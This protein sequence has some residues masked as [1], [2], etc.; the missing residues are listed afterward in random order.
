[1][2]HLSA[3][4]RPIP[5]GHWLT[6]ARIRVYSWLL[7][8]IFAAGLAVAIVR[9]L[10]GLVDARG[11]PLGY[12]FMAFWSAARLALGG[13]PEAVFDGA[14]ISAVQHAAVAAAPDIWFPWH[15]PPTTLLAVLPLGLLPYSAAL[16]AFMAASIALWAAF[17][18]RLLPDPRAWIVAAATPA[19]LINLI[20]G[21]NAFLTAA[22]AGFAVLWL[23][24]RPRA[25]GIL[26]GLLAIKP[27]LAVL[28]PVAL[29]AG[30]YWRSFAA[31]AATVAVFVATSIA[32]LGVGSLGAFV[33]HLAVS[34]AMA[35]HGAVPWEW[36]PSA[37]ILALSLGAAPTIAATIQAAVTL[38]AAICV[39][40]AWRHDATPFEAK[41]AVLFAASM[42][43]SPYI[44]TYDLVWDAV[45]IG[46]LA[47][48]GLRTAFA[49][50]E[51]DILFAAWVAPLTLVPF[52]LVS[53]VQIGCLVTLV[54]LAAAMRRALPVSAGA[55]S[56]PG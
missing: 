2:H 51:R 46:F 19:G 36:M 38:G 15:Y 39:W 52:Y 6:I 7:V 10:P 55:A 22:L 41:A 4:P 24:R 28:F 13:R 31:A 30:G 18:R 35:E 47:A 23:D 21:Q 54:L 26:I 12:D 40:V 25:A 44:F 43:V 27:H 9:A 14:A 29:V 45:A 11:K 8:A 56:F 20:D 33:D 49:R 42:L 37:D 3:A 34:Q 5:D 53:G 17:I 1:M 48:L 16:I 50:G 32:V